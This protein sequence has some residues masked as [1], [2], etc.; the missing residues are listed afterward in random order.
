MGDSYILHVLVVVFD[1]SLLR[2][3]ANFMFLFCYAP[4]KE[5]HNKNTH[6]LAIDFRLDLL[7]PHNS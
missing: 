2:I 7:W 1:A 6:S 3:S 5:T 4:T